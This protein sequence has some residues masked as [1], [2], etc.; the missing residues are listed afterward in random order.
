MKDSFLTSAIKQFEY[1]K[2]LAERALENLSDDQFFWQHNPHSNSIA[3]I[4]NHMAGNMHSRFT[5]FLIADGEKPWRNRD[6]EFEQPVMDRQ[7]LMLYWQQGWEQLFG[8]IS[9]LE[10]AQL[11]ELIYIRNEGHTIT[12]AINRQLAHYPYHVGQVIVIAKMLTGERWV[13]LSIP[14]NQSRHYNAGKFS[15]Q[16]GRRHFTDGI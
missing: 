6:A 5:D 2:A 8:A 9:Q 1:Y 7:R 12:E 15:Q 10:P 4:I 11:E 13:S 16:K 3:I 14:K